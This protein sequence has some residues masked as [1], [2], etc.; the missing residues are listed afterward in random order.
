MTN[1]DFASLLKETKGFVN[2]KRLEAARALA[3]M[4]PENRAKKEK[5]EENARAKHAEEKCEERKA[6]AAAAAAAAAEEAAEA[7]R[8]QKKIENARAKRMKNAEAN[9]LAK[10]RMRIPGN[11]ANALVRAAAQHGQVDEEGNFTGNARKINDV[12]GFTNFSA[13]AAAAA[14][15]T[16][17]KNRKSRKIRRNRS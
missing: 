6:G 12:S 10:T 15:P 17:R 4:S 1:A 14:N 8:V 2:K 16:L 9:L 3:T 11:T 13:A 7:E 5:E